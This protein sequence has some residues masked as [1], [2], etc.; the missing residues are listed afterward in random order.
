MERSL[1]GGLVPAFLDDRL[2]LF[3]LL[4]LLDRLDDF[5]A[6]LFLPKEKRESI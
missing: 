1:A 5:L 2:V 3:L 4:F 6:T